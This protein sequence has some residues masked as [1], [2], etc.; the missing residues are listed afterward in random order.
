MRIFLEKKLQTIKQIYYSTDILFLITLI[1]FLNVKLP[2]KLAGL[3]LIYA[4]RFDFKFGVSLKRENRI[5]LFYLLM[6]CVCLLELF[7][8]LNFKSNYLLLFGTCTCLWGMSFLML[9]QIKLAIEKSGVDKVR[10]ALEVFL[11]L[12]IIVSFYNLLLIMVETRSINP[13]MFEGLSYKYFVSTGDN[14]RGVMA[15]ICTANMIVN[16]FGLFYFLN[17]EKYWHSFACLIAV[18]TTTSNLG[19]IIVVIFLGIVAV[20]DKNRLHKS[21]VLAY[22]SVLIVFMVKISP[23]NLDYFKGSYEKSVKTEGA[24]VVAPA[25]TKWPL[26]TDSLL[27]VYAARKH[28][29]ADSGRL[30]EGV[31]TQ[32]ASFHEMQRKLN[33]YREPIRV[34]DSVFDKQEKTLHDK[35]MGLS[36]RLYGDSLEAQDI[37][38]MRPGKKNS[39]KLVSLS[40]TYSN[41]TGSVKSFLFGE[42]PGNFSSKMAFRAVGLRVDGSWPKK[43]V[44]YSDKFK[45]SHFK[46]WLFYR[47]QPPSEHS[48]T[49]YPN[50][51]VNQLFGEYGLLGAVLF[52]FCY[53]WF[54]IKRYKLLSYG[55]ILFPLL[56]IF[57]GTDYWFENLSI[58]IVF[59]TM[60]FLDLQAS[61]EAK[62]E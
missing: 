53:M 36:K 62:P 37:P 44:Y 11:V 35:I 30:T 16:A 5:P 4:V 48:V 3:I 49:N 59:E 56:I 39:G 46:L 57:L 61:R 34:T 23:S 24:L 21:I 8:N 43:Y 28:F 14:I 33:D 45:A 15:D 17:R 18:L 1:L 60:I 52:L 7:L 31:F 20:T 13:Y 40:Q 42:G 9:H 19:N 25:F 32:G 12:N 54:F 26:N 6:I 50:S 22:V 47:I 58:L 38:Y 55:K 41:M 29:K 27:F 2:V 10:R 51:C